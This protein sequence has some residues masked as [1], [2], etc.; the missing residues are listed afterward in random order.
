[1]LL[2][3]RHLFSTEAADGGLGKSGHCIRLSASKSIKM[4]TP[5]RTPPLQSK[6]APP[7]PWWRL[8]R[9][10]LTGSLRVLPWARASR[11]ALSE[12]RKTMGVSVPMGWIPRGYA[13]SRHA[14]LIPATVARALN[15]LG[16]SAAEVNA[17]FQRVHRPNPTKLPQGTGA[18]P[19][20]LKP[21]PPPAYPVME[22]HAGQEQGSCSIPG[23][24]AVELIA[25]LERARRAPPGDR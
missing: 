19:P 14:T 4:T 16:I 7:A 18:I 17:A 23:I 21:L 9:A 20:R 8:A 15:G 2:N 12:Y 25:S 6:P 1:L 13:L 10:R 11:A 22:R 3:M 5:Y 24:S